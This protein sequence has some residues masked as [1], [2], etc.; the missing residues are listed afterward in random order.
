MHSSV[1]LVID[2]NGKLFLLLRFPTM[3]FH[4]SSFIHGYLF[5]GFKNSW[6]L[7]RFDSAVVAIH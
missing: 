4:L 6:Q 2:L 3:P 1:H 7:G 5:Q